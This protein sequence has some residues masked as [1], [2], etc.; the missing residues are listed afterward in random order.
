MP[1]KESCLRLS[2]INLSFRGKD[3]LIK[4]EL[5]QSRQCEKKQTLF[6]VMQRK[7]HFF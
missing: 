1:I 6:T 5:S 2:A 7:T 3:D 4:H